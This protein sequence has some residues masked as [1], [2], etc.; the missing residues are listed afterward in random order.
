[1]TDMTARAGANGQPTYRWTIEPEVEL[2]LPLET[3]TNQSDAESWL[4][5]NWR[6]LAAAGVQTVRLHVDDEELYKMSLL[7]D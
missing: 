2:A 5:E 4:G 6:E 3:A 7:A 1:M